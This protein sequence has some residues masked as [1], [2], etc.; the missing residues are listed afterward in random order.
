[1]IE[2]RDLSRPEMRRISLRAYYRSLRNWR[3]WVGLVLCGCCSG[4]G[5]YVGW[6]FAYRA[7]IED[8]WRTLVFMLTCGTFGGIGGLLFSLAQ[9]R[10]M[11]RLIRE[12]MPHV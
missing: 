5:A 8:P 1:M 11:Q 7:Q 4:L 10:I 6:H 2:M 9:G 3:S 12:Q